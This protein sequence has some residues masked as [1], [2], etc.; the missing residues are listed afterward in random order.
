MRLCSTGI[1]WRH[2]GWSM[3]RHDDASA[4]HPATPNHYCHLHRRHLIPLSTFTSSTQIL[5]PSL[6]LLHS[7][8]YSHATT[9]INVEYVL[10]WPFITPFFWKRFN[11]QHLRTILIYAQIYIVEEKKFFALHRINYFVTY[12]SLLHCE[13]IFR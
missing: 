10:L 1:A 6:W 8:S 12:W 11:L 7:K 5:T 2:S 3:C 13:E 4:S 9:L